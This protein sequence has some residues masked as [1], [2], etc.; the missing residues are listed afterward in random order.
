MLKASLF[1]GLA[2]C[3]QFLDRTGEG[4]I[5]KVSDVGGFHP[6]E[7]RTPSFWGFPVEGDGSVA[8]SAANRQAERF[9]FAGN[10][11]TGFAGGA[12]NEDVLIGLGLHG[13][14]PWLDER[15]ME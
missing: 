8:R 14:A 6:I 4:K 11:A 3:V 10:A 12:D 2:E 5:G 7:G 13:F 1:G 9:E 15:A